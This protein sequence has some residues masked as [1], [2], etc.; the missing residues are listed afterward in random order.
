VA[1]A[2]L[3]A[4]FFGLVL[5]SPGAVY[6]EQPPQGLG[7]Q[8]SEFAELVAKL[9]RFE[10]TDTESRT[11]TLGMVVIALLSFGLGLVAARLLTHRLGLRAML[12]AGFDEGAAHAYLSLAYYALAIIAFL[13]A[14][15][16]VDIPLTAFAVVG[17]ALAIGVGF[18]SQNVVNNF[19]SGVILLAERP[20]K[21]GDLIELDQTF[22]NVERIGLRSTSVRSGDNIHMIVPNS[23]FL[24][25]RVINWTHNGSQVRLSVSV[26]VAYGSPTREVERLIRQAIDENERVLATPE[27]IVLFTEFGDNSLGFKALFWAHVRAM[28]DRMKIESELRYRIDELFR[29]AGVVIAFPQR[30]VHLDAEHPLPVQLVERSES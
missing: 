24:E 5:L 25:S 26:G 16:L 13:T 1:R 28:M 6:A 30:D 15:R 4:V 10:I 7:E 23:A 27:P 8:L 29:E 9:W 12:R 18:G 21:R 22:G 3:L 14:L 2:L 17:G 19:I 11:V 20:I